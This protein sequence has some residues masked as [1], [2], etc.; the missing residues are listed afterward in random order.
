MGGGTLASERGCLRRYVTTLEGLGPGFQQKDYDRG[1]GPRVSGG[2][3][4]LGAS[5]RRP[6]ECAL[7]PPAP[8]DQKWP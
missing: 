1:S 6:I 8:G 4:W 5:V 7:A 2:V 3:A